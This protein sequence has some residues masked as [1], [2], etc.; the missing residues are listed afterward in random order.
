VNSSYTNEG[1]DASYTRAKRRLD[2]AYRYYKTENRKD[3]SKKG[4]PVAMIP[5]LKEEVINEA[6]A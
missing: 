3:T 2:Y 6:S 1:G 4:P 5:Y